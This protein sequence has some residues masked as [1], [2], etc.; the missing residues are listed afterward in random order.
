MEGICSAGRFTVVKISIY[1]CILYVLLC[2]NMSP[3]EIETHFMLHRYIPVRARTTSS[4]PESLKTVQ[5]LHA[6]V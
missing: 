6:G 2:N 5:Q 1:P 3:F 4:L